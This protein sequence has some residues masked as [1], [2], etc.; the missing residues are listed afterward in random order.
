MVRYYAVPQYLR[1]KYMLCSLPFSSGTA[2]NA[3]VSM[4]GFLRG[5]P[6]SFKSLEQTIEWR[7]GL[8]VVCVCV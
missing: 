7:C 6:T 4:Q 1:S 3:L 2:M 8:N 5:R